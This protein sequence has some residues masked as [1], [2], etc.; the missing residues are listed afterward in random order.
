MKSRSQ[1]DIDY[2]E[3]IAPE[4]DAIVVEPRDYANDLLFKPF[5]DFMKNRN[6]ML[7]I[8]CGTGH[9]LVRYASEYDNVIGIDHSPGMLKQAKHK[10]LQNKLSNVE[11]IQ[12]DLSNF[13]KNTDKKF[14]LITMVG[15]LHHLSPE[16]FEATLILVKQSLNH[17]GLFL[18]AEPIET[19][20]V[21]PPELVK[22]NAESIVKNR[23]YS[24]H[25]EDPDE[26]PINL[27][28]LDLHFEK[29]GLNKVTESRGTEIFPHNFPPSENDKKVIREFHDKYGSEGHVYSA[30]YKV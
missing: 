6:N 10:C 2:H 11:L 17:E 27:N 3:I 29:S 13:L 25:A 1:I 28:T 5:N 12:T 8:G 26:A 4:Y 7:D 16:E 22:W 24:Q 23:H 20:F 19:S 15:C 21:Q 9:M 14:D 18:I 30:L